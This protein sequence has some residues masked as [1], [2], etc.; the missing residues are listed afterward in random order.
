VVVDDVVCCRYG[1]DHGTV[2]HTLSL[3]LSSFQLNDA[4]GEDYAQVRAILHQYHQL[5]AR[6]FG[7]DFVVS[8]TV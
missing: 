2:H 8:L 6:K 7:F 1:T 5:S 4:V 3:L